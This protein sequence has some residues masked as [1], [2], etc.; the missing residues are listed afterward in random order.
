MPNGTTTANVR[1]RA[2]A[3]NETNT[4]MFL[5]P[6]TVVDV[7]GQQGDWIQVTHNNRTG[8]IHRS[9]IRVDGE[10][11]AGVTAPPA[12]A[13][14]TPP[15]STTQPTTTPPPPSQPAQPRPAGE[16]RLPP[17]A[18]P[19]IMQTPLEAPGDQR[20]VVNPRD[21]LLNRLAADIWNRFGSL[22][23]VLSNELGID[24]AV[25]IAVFAVESGGRGF[26][27]DGRMIIRFE[28][29]VFLDY[30]GKHNRATYDQHF[31]FNPQQRW[32][33][34]KWRPDPNGPW[35][36]TD[37]DDFHGNQGREWEVFNFAS[38]FSDPM[39]KMSISMGSPQVMGFNFR[40]LGYNSVLDLFDAFASG[41]RLQVLGFF[42]FVRGQGAQPSP[43]V[44]ALRNMDFTEFARSYNG[45]G[46]AV[47]YGQLIK[48]TFDAFRAMRG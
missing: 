7:V 19:A 20:L 32:L 33:N 22:I 4:L 31:T 43:R 41:D 40:T 17:T 47:K 48:T 14:T 46:Q 36:P 38:H 8:F 25:A 5:T 13:T 44:Q 21:Q 2:G 10:A 12:P 3:G 35:L 9:F 23:N 27:P 28:N 42:D 45:P 18:T 6:N 15:A 24:P 16:L 37:R 26:G 39:A 34:H 11:P 29:Q 30:W 1:M